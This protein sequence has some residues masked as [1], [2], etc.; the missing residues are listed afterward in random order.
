MRKK[1]KKLLGPKN[2]FLELQADTKDG[3]IQEMIERLHANGMIKDLDGVLTAVRERE[4]KMSTGMN[5]GIAIP[6]GKT[7][8]VNSLV[9]AVGLKK[10]GV[11]F[12]CTDGLPATIFIMT[13]SPASRSGPHIQ[14]LAEV[15]KILRDAS[16]RER[17]LAAKDIS[18]IISV[19]S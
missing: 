15:S 6:H 4:E 5:N 14:F 19:F 11:D 10:N 2:V 12:A 17:L 8:C 18:A 9:A 7:D 16:S 3:I 1:L 13:I